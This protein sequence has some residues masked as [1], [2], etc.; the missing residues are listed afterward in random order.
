MAP[1]PSRNTTMTPPAVFSRNGEILPTAEA[2]VPLPSPAVKYGIAVF[3]TLRGYWNAADD[4]LY[5][6]RLEDHLARLRRSAETMQFDPLPDAG[7]LRDWVVALARAL[8]LRTDCNFRIQAFPDGS[9]ASLTAR[10]PLTVTIT[11]QVRGRPAAAQSGVACGVSSWTRIS[12]DSMPPRIKVAANYHNGRLAQ[13][14]AQ[15]A[16]HDHAILLNRAGTVAEGPLA[17]VVLIKD[18]QAVTPDLGSDILE[19]VTRATVLTLLPDRLGVACSERAVSRDELA[20]ADEAFFC[21]TGLEIL[22]IVALDGRPMGQGR[23]GPVTRRL[24]QVYLDVARGDDPAHPGW[25]T[26]VHAERSG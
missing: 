11:V 24:Q 18:G 16:G 13:L 22:P 20:D 14:E 6:F 21:S 2:S 5:L 17:C 19:S 10:G 9:D 3:D 26:P 1:V 25:R 15:A 8:E 4:E 23:P 12:T 7:T